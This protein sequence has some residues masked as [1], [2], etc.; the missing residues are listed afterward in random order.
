MLLKFSNLVALTLPP[1]TLAAISCRGKAY[2]DFPKDISTLCR[3][4]QSHWFSCFSHTATTDR[5]S[6]GKHSPLNTVPHWL[7]QLTAT[8]DLY[9]LVSFWVC[10]VWWTQILSFHSGTAKKKHELE[11]TS[12]SSEQPS[13]KQTG[14]ISKLFQPTWNWKSRGS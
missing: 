14:Y 7:C 10:K 6:T 12:P 2:I 8:A 9:L 11:E 4:N 13:A 1:L 5:S 3:M